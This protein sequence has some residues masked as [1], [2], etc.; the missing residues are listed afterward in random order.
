MKSNKTKAG[1]DFLCIT[2]KGTRGRDDE[3][4]VRRY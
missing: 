2:Q 4:S 1:G 3:I